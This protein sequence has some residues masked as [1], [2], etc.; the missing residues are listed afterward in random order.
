MTLIKTGF[1]FSNWNPVLGLMPSE[2][3]T[4]TAEWTEN[5][6]TITYNANG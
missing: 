1:T 3:K 2:A 5:Q 6:Y 4:S